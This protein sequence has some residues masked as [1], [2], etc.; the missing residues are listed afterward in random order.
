MAKTGSRHTHTRAKGGHRKPSG[1]TQYKHTHTHS[2]RDHLHPHKPAPSAHAPSQTC[3]FSTPLPAL[4]AAGVTLRAVT[5][6]PKVHRPHFPECRASPPTLPPPLQAGAAPG[7][8]N[9]ERLARAVRSPTSPRAARVE[10]AGLLKGGG[11]VGAR[12]RTGVDRRCGARKG[13]GREGG[14]R[15]GEGRGGCREGEGRGERGMQG[16]EGREGGA[17]R[18]RRGRGAE[19]AGEAGRGGDIVEKAG[20]GWRREKML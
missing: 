16:G 15:E 12:E 19:R 9:L 14:C 4:S 3:K 17:G 18:G 20:S 1:H 5:E 2:D 6:S 11:K 10:G 7:S 13:E 8:R